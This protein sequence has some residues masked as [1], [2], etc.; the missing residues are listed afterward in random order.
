MFIEECD[1]CGIPEERVFKDSWTG[2]N[3]CLQCLGQ[4]W[5]RVTNSPYTEGD[6]LE[7]L[8][9]DADYLTRKWS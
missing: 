5:D 4:V 7:A 2:K 1:C 9:E 8:L 3:L 6:N